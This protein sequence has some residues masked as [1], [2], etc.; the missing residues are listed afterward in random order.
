MNLLFN[1]FQI[2][3]FIYSIWINFEKKKYVKFWI[4]KNSFMLK[5]IKWNFVFI[6]SKTWSGLVVK[7]LMH[8]HEVWSSNLDKCV[9]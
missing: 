7:T 4:F 9:C 6:L 2:Y 8:L 1:K 3:V 5:I